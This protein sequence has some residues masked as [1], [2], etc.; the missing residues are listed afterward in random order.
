M[1]PGLVS[2]SWEDVDER[3]ERLVPPGTRKVYGIPRG[4]AIVAGLLRQR[5]IQLVGPDEAEVI[6]DDIIDSGETAKRYSERYGKPI[7]VLVNKEQEGLMGVWVEFPWE[8]GREG[9]LRDGLR[10]IIQTIGDDPDRTGLIETP[11]RVIAA[12]DELFS[13]YREQPGDVIK[14]TPAGEGG[15]VVVRGVPFRSTCER[16]LLPFWGNVDAAYLPGE[17]TIAAA[18]LTRLIAV[19]SRRL[20]TQEVLTRQIGQALDESGAAGVAVAFRARR[21]C[22]APQA[23]APDDGLRT[24]TYF[25]G[26]FETDGAARAE[27]LSADGGSR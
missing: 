3:L 16:H 8:G 1:M 13:G 11:D 25:S 22:A 17:R 19:C 20:Q 27:F 24:T 10:R 26:T 23:S 4:G 6:V 2:L 9:D 5:G 12:W 14:W 21:V 7:A 15:M 18:S